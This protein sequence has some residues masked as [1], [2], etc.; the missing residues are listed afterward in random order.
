MEG[1]GMMIENKS[2]QAFSDEI[3]KQLHNA[4]TC[5]GETTL[6]VS[7]GST[8]IELFKMLSTCEIE[9]KKVTV[10]LCDERCVPSF[11]EKSNAFLIRRYLLQNRAKEAYFIPLYD[12]VSIESSLENAPKNKDID[13]LI[14]GMGTDGHTA[15]LFPNN[16]KLKKAYNLQSETAYIH[17]TPASAPFERISMT[18]PT[19][20][21]ADNIY[22]HIEGEQ[23]IEVLKKALASGDMYTYPILSVLNHPNT[24]V[25]VYNT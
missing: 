8:P 13:V 19:I 17:I 14:L 1:V 25:K 7:G 22:L 6:A 16:E 2:I 12:D 9:W 10:L 5:K 24:K 3:I 18:L 4:F 20:L 23:K 21:G 15:S 11:S